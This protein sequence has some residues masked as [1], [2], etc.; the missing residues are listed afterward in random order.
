M[1]SEVI[2]YVSFLLHYLSM[3][4]LERVV[5]LDSV[6][7]VSVVSSDQQDVMILNMEGTLIDQHIAC[8]TYL[9]ISEALLLVP[10]PDDNFPVRLSSLLRS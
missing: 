1:A 3:S 7:F 10:H 6:E 9:L 8:D 5:F 2:R 4:C